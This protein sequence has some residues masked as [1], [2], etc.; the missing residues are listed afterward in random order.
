MLAITP[1]QFSTSTVPY[2]FCSG[3][4]GH[5][6]EIAR[7]CYP[8]DHRKRYR[9]VLRSLFWHEP[10]WQWYR[11]IAHSPLLRKLWEIQINL[12]EKLHRP[13]LRSDYPAQRRVEILIDHYTLAEQLLE[14]TLHEQAL[15]NGGATLAQI[16]IDQDTQYL[17]KLEY[18]GFPSKEGELAITMFKIGA[19]PR[20][21]RISFS[22]LRDGNDHQLF[23]GGLQ[24]SDRADAR[25][26]VNQASK[27]CHGLAPRRMLI[28][29]ALAFAKVL[30]SKTVLAVSDKFQPFKH[31]QDKF[32]SYDNC[33]SE[34]GGNLNLNGDFELPMQPVHKDYAD[35]PRKRR[36]KYR[37]QHTILQAIDQQVQGVL[38]GNPQAIK[39]DEYLD[40]S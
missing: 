7:V 29:A 40:L 20:L 22:L 17:F 8:L 38:S 23:I 14:R 12:P 25:S 1:E 9:M 10:S 11:Y 34:L 18:L 19:K 4:L 32:F 28:E 6:F 35:T 31:K 37:R 27:D 36:A 3:Y 5:L 16:A 15:L 2:R 33:W 26:I 24:G 21:A 30:G 39:A 13:I